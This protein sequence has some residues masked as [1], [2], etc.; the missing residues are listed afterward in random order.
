VDLK[1]GQKQVVE[2][3]DHSLPLPEVKF[4]EYPYQR[5]SQREKS[6]LGYYA[7]KRIRL[8]WGLMAPFSEQA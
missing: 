8:I 1:D 6:H 5:K 3:L 7:V 4:E 2:G